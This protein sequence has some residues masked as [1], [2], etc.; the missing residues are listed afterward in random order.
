MDEA[1]REPRN[2]CERGAEGPDESNSPGDEGVVAPWR[3]EDGRQ[4]EP[5]K[6]G[7]LCS[8]GTTVD[9]RVDEAGSPGE[10]LL[11]TGASRRSFINSQTV[12]LLQL[13]AASFRRVC[14]NGGQ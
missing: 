8:V 6:D 3:R 14:V 4:A 5:N 13:K 11:D 10:T 2:L 9:L 7:I 12:E 1:R